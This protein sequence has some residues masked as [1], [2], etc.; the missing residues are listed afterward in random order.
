DASSGGHFDFAAVRL[1]QDDSGVS[2]DDAGDGRV[3]RVST[4][5][6][7]CAHRVDNHDGA[8]DSGSAAETHSPHQLARRGREQTPT[9]YGKL[10]ALLPPSGGVRR[11]L[12]PTPP[13]PLTSRRKTRSPRSGANS[14]ACAAAQLLTCGSISSSRASSSDLASSPRSR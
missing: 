9:D 12:R 6:R 13:P 7:H 14:S 10:R 5:P 3:I 8:V 1:S 11:A 4:G 2:G